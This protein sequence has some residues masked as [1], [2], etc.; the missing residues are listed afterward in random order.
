MK[1]KYVS[2]YQIVDVPKDVHWTPLRRKLHE[3]FTQGKALLVAEGTCSQ[4]HLSGMAHY[5]AKDL[6]LKGH[7]RKT[8]EGVVAWASRR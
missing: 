3:A 2:R 8:L 7:T 4:G 1:R 6:G 5:A